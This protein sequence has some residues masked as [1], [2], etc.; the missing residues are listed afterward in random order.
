MDVPLV[1]FP[2]LPPPVRLEK[3]KEGGYFS[4]DDPNDIGHWDAVEGEAR[5]SISDREGEILAALAYR[6]TVIEIGTGLG[7]STGYLAS[8]ARR[9]DTIDPSRWVAERIFP[10]L[11][12][13]GNVVCHSTLGAEIPKPVDLVFIDAVHLAENVAA[14]LGQALALVKPEGLI[15]M[16]DWNIDNVKMGCAG[17]G[18]Y[19]VKT[20]YGLGLILPKGAKH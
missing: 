13:L 2:S 7:V 12:L 9:V 17:F 6:R 8:S 16:H 15:V 18:G 4:P 14:D 5:G 20:E 1:A 19:E 10:H 3:T 11:R